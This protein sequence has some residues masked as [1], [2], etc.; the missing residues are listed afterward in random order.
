M[1]LQDF[2]TRNEIA[3]VCQGYL[4]MSIN[5]AAAAAVFILVCLFVY[6]L[7]SN[8]MGKKKSNILTWWK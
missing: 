3:E 7:L 1:A 6:V 8:S 2:T 5:I 4:I